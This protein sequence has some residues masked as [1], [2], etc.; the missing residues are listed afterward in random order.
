MTGIHSISGSSVSKKSG[1]PS[2][3][4]LLNASKSLRASSTFSCD[5]AY[6]S[7]AKA[8]RPSSDP[9]TDHNPAPAK[10]MEGGCRTLQ[11]DTTRLSAQRCKKQGD[12]PLARLF[13]VLSFNVDSG[14]GAECVVEPT[15]HSVVPVIGPRV[16]RVDHLDH[17]LRIKEGQEVIDVTSLE[18]GKTRIQQLIQLAQLLHV[19]L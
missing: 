19:L 18:R 15:A 10:L 2:T 11:L 1:V 14:P 5:I 12:G 4:V 9:D 6:S 16:P 7:G 17:D 3:N 13:E 8:R